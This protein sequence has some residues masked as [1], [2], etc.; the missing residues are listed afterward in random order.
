M[1]YNALR[2]G[3]DTVLLLRY[4]EILYT[5]QKEHTVTQSISSAISWLQLELIAQYK[6]K[7]SGGT[8]I[9]TYYSYL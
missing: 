4:R 2:Y 9:Y 7:V 3:K 5:N 8:S 6:V 1:R